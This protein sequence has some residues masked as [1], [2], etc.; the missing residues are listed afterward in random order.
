MIEQNDGLSIPQIGLG[1]Y[2][3]D[4]DI[5]AASVVHALDL[6]Y[7]LLDTAEQYQNETGVGE[8]IRRSGVP[9]EELYVTT[10]L[11]NES[12]GYDA[13][14][15]GFDGSLS[16][17]GLDYLDL[18]LIHWPMTKLDKY[19]DS[20]RAFETLRDEGRVRSIGVANFQV[21]HLERLLSESSVVPVVNQIELHPGL[22][23]RDLSAYNAQHGILTEAWSPL[24]YGNL[25]SNPV[26]RRLAERYGKSVAQVLIRWH[27]QLG[28][29]LIPKTVTPSRMAENLEVFDFALDQADL[30]EIA[31][32]ET[33]IRNAYD[34]DLMNA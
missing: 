34:P 33:G 32:L 1:L 11:G 3:P 26:L 9:R 29:V 23:R 14:M 5:A 22:Q 30:D 19:V 24:A 4:N 25:L 7:R 18:F 13:T 28:N 12:H 6:G 10:K 27:V 31:E 20:W 2:G 16:R 21:P 15:A 17:L 8:G